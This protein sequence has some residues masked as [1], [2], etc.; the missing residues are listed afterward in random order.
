M[1]AAGYIGSRARGR[2]RRSQPTV[3]SAV[4]LPASS[5]LFVGNTLAD[6]ENWPV[7]LDHSNYTTTGINQSIA[8]VT[9]SFIGDT[10]S[11]SE[12]FEDGD[13]NSFSI[14]VT[15]SGGASRTFAVA[16]RTVVHL[17][18]QIVN[19]LESQDFEAETGVQTY[20]TSVAFSGADLHFDVSAP[21]GITIDPA[22]GVLAFDTDQLT[23]PLDTIITVSVTNS[24]GT[25]SLG[26][27]ILV[28][29]PAQTE[30]LFVNTSNDS[31]TFESAGPT[32][33]RVFLDNEDGTIQ[34][35]A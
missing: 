31:V 25:A 15:D 18:P 1:I 24:G 20:D 12:A 8:A 2:S 21:V 6:T 19:G 35:V 17:A 11:A 14:T 26:L 16:P 10:N 4:I 27:P 32:P 3:I 7:F 34:R 29:A 13:L 22:S 23:V 33:T 9:V 5:A 28:A 30:H